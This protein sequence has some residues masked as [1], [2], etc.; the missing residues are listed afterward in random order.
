MKSELLLL[1]EVKMDIKEFKL[2]GDIFDEELELY[3][4][5]VI[6]G[7]SFKLYVLVGIVGFKCCRDD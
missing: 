2:V 4:D 6:C 7:K 5:G 3:L 1:S